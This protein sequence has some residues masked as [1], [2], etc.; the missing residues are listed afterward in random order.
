[1]LV[2]TA[3]KHIEQRSSTPG[4]ADRSS[5][6]TAVLVIGGVV[7]PGW[8]S[9]EGPPTI[10]ACLTAA[11]GLVTTSGVVIPVERTYSREARVQRKVFGKMHEWL[12]RGPEWGKVDGPFGE[13]Q[14]GD[15]VRFPVLLG[16]K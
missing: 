7:A 16:I 4:T 14:D 12:V 15:C 6:K 2:A 5:G 1:M 9:F 3:C 11:G 8:H 13:L 10:L